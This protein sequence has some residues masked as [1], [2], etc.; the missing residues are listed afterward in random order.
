MKRLLS[1][2]LL[3]TAVS[4][5]AMFFAAQHLCYYLPWMVWCV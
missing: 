1:G 3:A 2:G 4:V 5:T